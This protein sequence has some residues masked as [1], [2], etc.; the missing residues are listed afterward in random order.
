MLY[1]NREYTIRQRLSRML[2]D[3]ILATVSAGTAG[4]ATISTTN[5]PQFY[6]KGDDYFNKAEYE[7][8]TYSGTNV[9]VSRLASDWVNA[10]HVL[11]VTPDAGS[12]YATDSLL[13][14]HRIFYVV[15]LR[16]AINQA[17][18]MYARKYAVDLD[19]ETTVILQE[20]TSNDGNTLYTYE[21]SLPTNLLYIYRA[22]TEDTKSGWKLTGTVSG[23][24][25]NGETV[26]GGTSGA[27]GILSYG[28]AASTYILVR[29]VDGNFEVGETVTGGTSGETC[30]TLTAV[31]VKTVGDGRFPIENIIDPR[32][33]TVLKDYPPKIKFDETHYDITAD[34]RIRLEG[35][36]MQE[37][38]SADTDYIFLPPHELIEV[39][40]T[41]LP[42]SKLESNNLT[43]TF[44]KCLGTRH[45]VE[46]RPTVPGYGKRVTE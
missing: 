29:E 25:T 41:F 42:F 37:V 11:S 7:V 22:T 6:S 30:S 1:S 10:T 18:E 43:A 19:D 40:A 28:P 32:D 15:E 38:V 26:T 5:P 21:Y 16:D 35:Q 33:Y 45:R 39:A 2:D 14:L 31:E 23:A 34:L 24:F 44:N 9:G 3:C 12:A 13:E 20:T 8:Y 36:G 46:S 17:I 27:T 4:T